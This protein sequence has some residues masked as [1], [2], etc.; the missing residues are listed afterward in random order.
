M[1]PEEF[2]EFLEEGVETGEERREEEKRD[3]QWSPEAG[4]SGISPLAHGLLKWR[5]KETQF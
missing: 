5:R 2:G 1:A 3:F 4:M